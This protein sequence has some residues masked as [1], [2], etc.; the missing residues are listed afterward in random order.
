[1]IDKKWFLLI[2]GKIT[3]PFSPQE[4]QNALP[5]HPNAL[6]WGK[7]TS[8]WLEPSDWKKTISNPSSEAVQ[9][10]NDSK[11]WYYRIGRAEKGPFLLAE[12]V[13]LLRKEKDF[14]QI[15]IKESHE[16]GWVEIYAVPRIVETLGITRRSSPRVP[17]MGTFT[18]EFENLSTTARVVTISEGGIGLSEPA[19]LALGNQVRGVIR[20]AHLPTSINCNC[21]VVYL[22][23]DGYTG[24]RFTFIPAEASS[25]IIEYVNQFK[26]QQA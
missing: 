10:L 12:L 19:G 14:T 24:L 21:E 1:M 4:I 15:E 8:E 11:K 13:D 2:D 7:G 18:F 16:K 25:A 5:A 26:S 6:I 23:N 3:G 22:G 9:T 17:I 20:S